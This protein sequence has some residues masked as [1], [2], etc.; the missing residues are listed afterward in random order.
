MTHCVSSTA[1]STGPAAP[2]TLRTPRTESPIAR[3]SGGAPP[4]SV[5]SSAAPRLPLRRRKLLECLVQ[6]LVEHIAECRIG[7]RGVIA[8]RAADQD[9]VAAV[10]RLLDR[11][12]PERRLADACLALDEYERRPSGRS[13]D[14]PPSRLSSASRP[15][16]SRVFG[17]FATWASS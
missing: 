7:E 17:A 3:G 16:I 12:L 5:S 6:R 1:T 4:V 2:S 9:A 13:V 14:E 10:S 15:M 11:P 8:V